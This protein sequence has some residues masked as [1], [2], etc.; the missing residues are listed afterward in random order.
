MIHCIKEEHEFLTYPSGKKVTIPRPNDRCRHCK[1]FRF[2][3]KVID[4]TK[5][6]DLVSD[7]NFHDCP[8]KSLKLG[9]KNEFT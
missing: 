4:I 7:Y 9:K 6:T 2:Q 3:I 5:Q 1:R 8:N